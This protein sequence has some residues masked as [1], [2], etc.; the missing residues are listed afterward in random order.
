M[1]TPRF[2]CDNCG[3][4]VSFHAKQ[5]PRCDRFFQSVRCPS[6]GFTGEEALFT[7]GRTPGCP[8][9]GYAV[10]AGGGRTRRPFKSRAGRGEEKW[11]VTG[12][13]PLWLYL[14]AAV[15]FLGICVILF[16]LLKN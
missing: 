13:P 1:R 5:C 11:D 4:E 10:P 14:L 9:C 12:A 15:F 2:F 6:C 16:T 8:V 7:Q 3:A